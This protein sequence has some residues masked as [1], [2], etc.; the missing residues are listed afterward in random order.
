MSRFLWQ[1]TRIHVYGGAGNEKRAYALIGYG[2][3]DNDSCVT[4]IRGEHLDI[5]RLLKRF[6]TFTDDDVKKI[7]H[8]RLKESYWADD[9]SQVIRIA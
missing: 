4:L 1:S 3:F 7:L 9:F 6:G 2:E 8:L 5:P